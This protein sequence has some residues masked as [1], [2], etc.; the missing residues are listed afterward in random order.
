MQSPRRLPIRGDG[1]SDATTERSQIFI[2]RPKN[3][4]QVAEQGRSA[5]TSGKWARQIMGTP[6][7][8]QAPGQFLGHFLRSGRRLDVMLALSQSP[9]DF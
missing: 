7:G 6:K 4:D 9:G 8:R 3:R 5:L 2:G 1:H